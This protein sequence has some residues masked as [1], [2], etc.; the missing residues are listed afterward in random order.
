MREGFPRGF[1]PV[2]L[3]G[4]PV[5]RYYLKAVVAEDFTVP[6]VLNQTYERAELEEWIAPTSRAGYFVE[7]TRWT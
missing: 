2:G 6:P 7:N 3:P 5:R 1:V 4:D